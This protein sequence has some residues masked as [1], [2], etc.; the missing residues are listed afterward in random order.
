MS[1]KIMRRLGAVMVVVLVVGADVDA[2]GLGDM[3]ISPSFDPLLASPPHLSSTTVLPGDAQAVICQPDAGVNGKIMTLSD[4]VKLG[5]CNNPQLPSAWSSI[6]AQVAQLGVAKAAYLP[7]ITASVS[8]LHQKT[9]Y[10]AEQSQNDSVITND[11]RYVTL[12][13]RLLDF[14][15]RG[16][17]RRAANALLDAALASRDATLQKMLTDIISAYF[18]AQTAQ[19]NR[20]AK[21]QGEVLARQT[22]TTAKKREARG[23]GARSDTLQADTA[24]A[25]AELES[26]RAMGAYEKALADLVIAIGLPA[27]SSTMRE[28]MLAPD[29]LTQ[30]DTLHQDLASWLA[31]AQNQHPALLAA[32]AQLVSAKEKLRA[33]RSDGLPTLDFTQSQYINGRPN[34][35]IS[36]VQSRESV[37]GVTLNIPLFDGFSSTYKVRGAQAQIE[38]KEAEIQYTE[39]QVLSD[40]VKAHADAVAALRNLD[41][42]QRLIKVAGDALGLVQSKYDKGISDISDMLN[43]QMAL[44]DAEQERI[45]ALSEWSSARLRLLSN[46]GVVGLKDVA[47]GH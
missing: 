28:L 1:V 18:D 2:K 15:G 20:D 43:V 8:R 13:W 14:G 10:P 46:A 36:P 41:A 7:T 25:K 5:L 19:A 3:V 34:Q 39:N 6:K 27:Q 22:W 42:S 32:R 29:D 4:A 35:G 37:V 12:T 31:V 11:T 44:A 23:V 21:Q 30:G 17:N 24:L 16:A 26:S 33:A 40:V 47:K 45:R 38:G 9:T